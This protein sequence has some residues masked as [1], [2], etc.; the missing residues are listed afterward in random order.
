MMNRSTNSWSKAAI[1][2]LGLMASASVGCQANV[3]GQTLPSA[4][5]LEDDVQYF[6]AGE[7]TPLSNQQRALAAY[8]LEQEASAAGFAPPVP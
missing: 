2:S 5:F 1:V 6:P 8:R 3:A 4:Y 7:E